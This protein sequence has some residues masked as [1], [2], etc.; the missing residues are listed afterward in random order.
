MVDTNA[1]VAEVQSRIAESYPA[2]YAQRIGGN[3][4]V[5]GVT[6]WKAWVMALTPPPFDRENPKQRKLLPRTIEHHELA[7]LALDRVYRARGYRYG[8]PV[9][10]DD[11]L[12]DEVARVFFLDA[13]C[14]RSLLAL[15]AKVTRA[16]TLRDTFAGTSLTL[17]APYGVMNL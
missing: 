16:I 1:I 13:L 5:G 4:N 17:L 11:V 6:S 14:C 7:L 8:D 2:M 3:F 10:L 15:A 9:I 12:L